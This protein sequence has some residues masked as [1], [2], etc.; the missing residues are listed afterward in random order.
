MLSLLWSLVEVHSQSFPRLSFMSQT[1]A[2]HSYLDLSEVGRPD[3][4]V[5][6]GVQCITDLTTCCTIA[7]GAH[8]GDWYFPNGTKLHFPAPSVDIYRTRVSQ[9]V[10]LRRNSG[11]NSP[12]GIYRCDIS[13]NAV[14][15]DSEQSSMVP[16][17]SQ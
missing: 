12:T 7:N 2:N 1:L 17:V 11:A 6:E 14:H 10:D 4:G 15:D 16:L 5:G 3:F 8:R 9:R 13:T